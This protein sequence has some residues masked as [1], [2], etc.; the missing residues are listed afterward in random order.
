M[1]KYTIIINPNDKSL[2]LRE[3]A[4]KKIKSYGLILTTTSS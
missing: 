3:N 4:L 2:I 1:L